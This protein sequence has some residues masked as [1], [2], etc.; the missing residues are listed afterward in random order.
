MEHDSPPA[1]HKHGQADNPTRR[2]G[3]DRHH[4]RVAYSPMTWTVAKLHSRVLK[5][6]PLLEGDIEIHR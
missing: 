3:S 2:L 5:L 6:F 4:A 1:P